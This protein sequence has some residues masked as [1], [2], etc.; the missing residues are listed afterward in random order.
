MSSDCYQICTS[1]CPRPHLSTAASWIQA[2]A[3]CGTTA[4]ARTTLRERTRFRGWD[5]QR[6]A[7]PPASAA[8]RVTLVNS[9]SV[10]LLHNRSRAPLQRRAQPSPAVLPFPVEVCWKRYTVLDIDSDV[11]VICKRW[12][13]VTLL[14]KCTTY[15]YRTYSYLP[16]CCPATWGQAFSA[17]GRR[18]EP[19]STMGT[20][21]HLSGWGQNSL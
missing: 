3:L 18:A 2:M 21:A 13:K 15:R 7:V 16:A 1:I 14:R 5:T 8:T 20:P 11:Y 19:P 9:S 6:P 17:A 10:G 12:C 4:P